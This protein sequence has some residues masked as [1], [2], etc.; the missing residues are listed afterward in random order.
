MGAVE[1]TLYCVELK[2]YHTGEQFYKI[3]L[4]TKSVED[5]FSEDIE[6]FEIV[7][8]HGERKLKLYDAVTKETQLLFKFHREGRAYRPQASLSGYTECFR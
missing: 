2:H 6:R 3:G 8:V 1:L 4:T 7:K 5:R